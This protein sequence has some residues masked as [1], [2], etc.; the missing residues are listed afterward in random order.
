MPVFAKRPP[1]LRFQFVAAKKESTLGGLPALEAL[2]QPFG[3]WK[4]L[5]ALSG[6]DPR[7][8]TRHGYHPDLLVAQLLYCLCW[9]GASLADAERLNDEPLARALARTQK[10][11]DQTQ[12]GQ[13]LRAQ[14]DDSIAAFWKLIAEFVAWGS[15]RAGP[16]AEPM[17]AGPKFFSTT[18]RSRCRGKISKARRAIMKGTSPSPGKCFGSA[19]FSCRRSWM[20]PAM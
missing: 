7:P 14:S 18:R 17:R 11:A 12:L 8:R 13:W 6:L 16:R 3:L 4:K 10:F 2:A 9:G 1:T 19:P 20:R 5:R 15:A